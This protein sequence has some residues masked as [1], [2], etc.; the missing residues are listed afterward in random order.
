LRSGVLTSQ[1][2][3]HQLLTQVNPPPADEKALTHIPFT[4]VVEECNRFGGYTN[5]SQGLPEIF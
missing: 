4:N 5:M 2:E 3:Y 1:S